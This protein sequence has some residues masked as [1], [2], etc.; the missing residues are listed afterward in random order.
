MTTEVK[1]KI[2]MFKS[3]YRLEYDEYQ[4]IVTETNDHIQMHDGGCGGVFGRFKKDKYNP[5]QSAAW[6]KYTQDDPNVKEWLDDEWEK[7]LVGNHRMQKGE[8]VIQG[9]LVFLDPITEKDLKSRGTQDE[10]RYWPV[11]AIP[12]PER[13]IR[14][15]KRFQ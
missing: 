6:N 2:W 10:S 4:R 14:H 15:Q 9:Y 1:S 8:S 3:L 11:D 12:A 13:Y 5:I 7:D